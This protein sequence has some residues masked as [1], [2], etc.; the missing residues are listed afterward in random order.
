MNHDNEF[1]GDFP[2]E[3]IGGGNPYHRCVHCK[4]SVPEINYS[5]TGHYDW[6]EYRISKSL[7]LQTGV[8]QSS[9]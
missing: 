7:Q 6:C 2:T 1:Y 3:K 4:R 9:R 8:I 5:L